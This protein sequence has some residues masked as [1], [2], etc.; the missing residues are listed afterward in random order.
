MLQR[1]LAGFVAMATMW[2]TLQRYGKTR[3]LQRAARATYQYPPNAAGRPLIRILF[4][5]SLIDRRIGRCNGPGLIWLPAGMC[6]LL[7]ALI[8]LFPSGVNIGEN[9]ILGT[10]R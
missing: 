4:R 5:R 8:S 3:F 10:S 1:L 6:L 2:R 7:M 9:A